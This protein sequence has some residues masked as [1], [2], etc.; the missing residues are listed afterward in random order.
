MS[1][2]S[3]PPMDLS[4]RVTFRK[5][6]ICYAPDTST[7]AVR[8]IGASQGIG[9]VYQAF[10][11]FNQPMDVLNNAGGRAMLGD[12]DSSFANGD[13]FNP[14]WQVLAN[15]ADNL[16]SLAGGFKAGHSGGQGAMYFGTGAP[17]AAHPVTSGI[18]TNGTVYVRWDGGAGTT[19]YQVRAGAWVG[20]L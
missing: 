5:G 2:V 9:P 12:R 13:P 3:L 10:D 4:N 15:A 19:F 14:V 7:E 16:S 17:G 11:A 18:P 6:I 8:M 1:S 20:I